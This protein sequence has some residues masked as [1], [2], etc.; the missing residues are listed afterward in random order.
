MASGFVQPKQ[1]QNTEGFCG[2][3]ACFSPIIYP[4]FSPRIKPIFHVR[5]DN[6]EAE[7]VLIPHLLK[8]MSPPALGHRS[9]TMTLCAAGSWA[10]AEVAGG[11]AEHPAL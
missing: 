5:Y 9:M 11:R 3:L 6:Q 7:L 4:I 8:S 10:D 1:K 2:L